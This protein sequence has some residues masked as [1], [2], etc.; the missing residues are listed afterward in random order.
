MPVSYLRTLTHRERTRLA[1]FHLAAYLA[2]VAG[3]VNA[4]GFLAVHQY[5]S[6]MSG[7]VSSIAD[8][9]A[10]SQFALI[11][12]G[13][14][15]LMAFMM[16][17]ACTAILVNWARRKGLHS[18]YALPLVLEACLLLCFGVVGEN[19]GSVRWLF[20][21]LTVSLLCFVMGLQNA[22]ITKLSNAEIRTTHITGMVTDIGIELGKLC[23]WNF[24]HP[25]P[26]HPR[27]L[28]NRGKMKMLTVLV[29][30]FFLG[31]VIG[32]LGFKHIGFISTLPLAALLLILAVVPVLEDFGFARG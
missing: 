20:V 8:Q 29:G 4:G 5:T 18:E 13:L 16:G 30:C 7:I 25:D 1:N 17:A 10:L 27:V 23:Y 3:A 2:F 28:A 32:A 31:G 22:I 9:L 11:L 19:L 12:A 26:H 6:H 14:G 24:P 21:P 15:A